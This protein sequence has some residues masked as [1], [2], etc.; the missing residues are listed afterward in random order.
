[1]GVDFG[2][3][4]HRNQKSPSATQSAYEVTLKIYSGH[5]MWICPNGSSIMKGYIFPRVNLLHRKKA[6]CHKH[7]SLFD[8]VSEM[9]KY[10]H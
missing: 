1:M 2:I 8:K 6:D 9:S 5:S 3:R 7:V 4:T 10:V